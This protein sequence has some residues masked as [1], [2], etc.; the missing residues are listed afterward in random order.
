MR[1]KIFVVIIFVFLIFFAAQN[2]S[3][4]V[5]VNNL[6][7]NARDYNSKTVEIKGE[8]I[9]DVM[10]RGNFGW[11]NI[12]DNTGAIGVWAKK[13]DLEKIEFKGGYKNI[14]DTIK[15]IGTFNRAC[16]EHGG[17]TDIHAEEL[18]IAKRGHRVEHP[19]DQRKVIW[20][21][22]LLFVVLGLILSNY[23]AAKIAEKKKP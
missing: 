2:C 20:L 13:E 5:S 4:G 23:L 18:L 21:A 8:A 10:I 11:I 6:I 9:G 16:D 12:L 19:I 7:E 14:G 3:E 17:D 22:V 15:V 1:K